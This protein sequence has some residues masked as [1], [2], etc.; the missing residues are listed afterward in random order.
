MRPHL[1]TINRLNN[2]GMPWGSEDKQ[3][4]LGLGSKF[5]GNKSLGLTCLRHFLCKIYFMGTGGL[6]AHVSMCTSCMSGA[7]SLEEGVC[8][9]GNEVVDA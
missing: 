4:V 7:Q 8:S 1:K 5:F 3:V 6:F 2:Q 9:S